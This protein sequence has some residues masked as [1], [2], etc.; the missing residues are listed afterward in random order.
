[1]DVPPYIEGIQQPYRDVVCVVVIKN[2]RANRDNTTDR[3]LYFMTSSF[4]RTLAHARIEKQH[5]L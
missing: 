2:E 5:I 1:M 4:F 3:V